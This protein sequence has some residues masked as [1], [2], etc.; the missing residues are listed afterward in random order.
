M[1]CN[2]TRARARGAVRMASGIF[3]GL[4]LKQ[5]KRST[6]LPFPVK[7]R[8]SLLRRKDEQNEVRSI[9]SIRFHPVF[10]PYLNN[11]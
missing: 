5:L 3:F 1:S 7:N 6:P 2:R 10:H 4:Q 8:L 11:V 9:R